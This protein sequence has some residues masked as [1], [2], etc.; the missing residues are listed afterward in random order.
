MWPTCDSLGPGFVSRDVVIAGEA[1]QSRLSPRKQSG[2]LRR[3]APRND[4]NLHLPFDQLQ[5]Q[6]GD[7][8][9]RVEALRAGLGA[10]HDGVAAI[11]PERVLEIVE[12]FAGCLIA[13]IL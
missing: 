9:R 10:V 3:F 4:E 7:G 6:L 1:K 13:R 2:L 11:K 12:A 8:F 5:F